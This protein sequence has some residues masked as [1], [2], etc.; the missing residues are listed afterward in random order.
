MDAF[1]ELADLIST[2][3]SPLPVAH[4]RRLVLRATASVPA[5][6]DIAKAIDEL[7]AAVA[8]LDLMMQMNEADAPDLRRHAR[9]MLADLKNVCARAARLRL[10]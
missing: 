10:N 1:E 7:H 6:I 2:A 8:F 4:I 3:G 9:E 5:S